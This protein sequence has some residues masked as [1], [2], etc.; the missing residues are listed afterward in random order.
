M[1]NII[2]L[3]CVIEYHLL[4]Y[5]MTKS[6]NPVTDYHK[7]EYFV[8][9][10]MQLMGAKRHEQ[11]IQNLNVC[12]SYVYNMVTAVLYTKAVKVKLASLGRR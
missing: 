5:S 3:I 9:D 1:P 4:S 10:S 12:L 6:H 11:A 8:N 2:L 7:K